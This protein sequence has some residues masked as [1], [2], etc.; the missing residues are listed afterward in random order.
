MAERWKPVLSPK[1]AEIFEGLGY[2]EDRDF[3]VSPYLDDD[4]IVEVNENLLP[5]RP[6]PTRRRHLP[7]R[8]LSLS[9][10]LRVQP[11]KPR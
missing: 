9:R 8:S 1:V 11:R 6:N 2:V 3:Y 10:P 7:F 5:L 4:Y